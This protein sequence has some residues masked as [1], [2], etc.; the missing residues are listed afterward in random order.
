MIW[1]R[2]VSKSEAVAGRRVVANMKW[3][4]ERDCV[5]TESGTT[6]RL[7]YPIREFADAGNVLVVVLDV[8]SSAQPLS[9]FWENVFGIS[10]EGR[11]AA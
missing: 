1:L 5:L 6:L 9:D 4:I 3:R 2:I 8:P 11:P 10:A 7:L